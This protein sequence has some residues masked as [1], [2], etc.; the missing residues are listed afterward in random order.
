MLF[1]VVTE[2]FTI[3]EKLIKLIS[4]LLHMIDGYFFDVNF[5]VNRKMS[6]LI[7]F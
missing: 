4:N 3:E 7:N 6:S 2:N 5:N 1:K